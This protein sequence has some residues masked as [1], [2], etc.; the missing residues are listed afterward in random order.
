[1]DEA[2]SQYRETDF[3]SRPRVPKLQY[4]MKLTSAIKIENNNVQPMY[5]ETAQNLEE[6]QLMAFCAA[7]ATARC[8]G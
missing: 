3:L 8:L 4:S 1:M 2:V 7:E 6:L 5:L